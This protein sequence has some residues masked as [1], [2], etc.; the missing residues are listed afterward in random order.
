MSLR[1]EEAIA[2]VV[3]NIGGTVFVT[4]PAKS[5]ESTFTNLFLEKITLLNSNEPYS[6]VQQYVSQ[7]NDVDNEDAETEVV[8]VTTDGVTLLKNLPS[9]SSEVFQTNKIVSHIELNNFDYAIVTALRDLQYPV[10]VSQ[11]SQ[12]AYTYANLAYNLATKL[13]TSVFHFFAPTDYQS[14]KSIKLSEGVL[15]EKLENLSLDSIVSKFNV[16]PFEVVNK[17]SSQKDA[18]LFLGQLND[19]LVN[20]ANKENALLIN[21]DRKSVV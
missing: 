5:V 17:A 9:F 4:Q 8:T 11:T 2:K 20:A 10:L 18:V 15:L 12:E 3:K 19:E 13:N 6:S 14:K 16:K 21:I 1:Q 7:S